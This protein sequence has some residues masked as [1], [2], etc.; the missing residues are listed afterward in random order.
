MMA[1]FTVAREVKGFQLGLFQKF[2]GGGA[3]GTFLSCG[4]RVLC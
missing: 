2:S 1:K 3:T 4:G